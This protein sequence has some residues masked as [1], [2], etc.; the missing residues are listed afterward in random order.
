MTGKMTSVETPA[1]KEKKARSDAAGDQSYGESWWVWNTISSLKGGSLVAYD[2][3]VEEENFLKMLALVDGFCVTS[4]K[5]T[6]WGP[7]SDPYIL[8]WVRVRVTW[9]PVNHS[10]RTCAL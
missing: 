3:S 1:Y 2:V 7:S 5:R 6:F 8:C 9:G 10:T 4:R